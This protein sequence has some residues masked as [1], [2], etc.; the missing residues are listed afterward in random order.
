VEPRV[1]GK[2]SIF[3]GSVEATFTEVQE[4]NRLALDWRFKNWPD[5]AVSKVGALS[6]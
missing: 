1:G 3:G 6:I 5:G 4:P 2:F